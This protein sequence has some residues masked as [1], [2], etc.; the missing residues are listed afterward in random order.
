MELITIVKHQIIFLIEHT[1]S[2]SK[3][4]DYTSARVSGNSHNYCR[5]P[6]STSIVKS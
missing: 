6:A 3:A 4:I 5:M 2:A 1:N